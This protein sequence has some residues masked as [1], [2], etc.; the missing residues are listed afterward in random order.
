MTTLFYLL[1]YAALIGFIF[2]AVTKVHGYLTSSPL[3]VRWE[4]YPVPHEG[5][6]AAYGGSFM[7][8]KEWWTKGRHVS[9]MGDLI[10]LLKEV[11]FLEATYHHNKP[12]WIRTYPFHL[13]MYM[14]MGGIMVVMFAVFLKFCGV[15]DAN[16]F[17][18]FIANVINAISLLGLLGTVG[19]GISLIYRRVSDPG[20][21]K[22]SSGEQYFNLAAFVVFAIFGL[23]AWATQPSFFAMGRD[24]MYNMVTFNFQPLVSSPFAIHLFLGFF[25]MIWVP[26]TNMQHLIYKY[27]T[28]H[29]IRWGD[30]PTNYSEANQKKIQEALQLKPT[31]SADHIAGDGVKTWVDIATTNP[32]APKK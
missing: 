30:M 10:A 29:D 3:H 22:Y 16:G 2:F 4:L 26:L 27:F 20:L 21:S 13:G 28:Y 17:M 15:S 1:A 31:W 14:M 6:K 25:L 23:A 8:E 24:F 7:D 11:L 18:I 12:L 9:H 19:G 5:K 32:A